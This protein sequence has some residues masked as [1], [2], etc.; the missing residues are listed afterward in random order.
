MVKTQL[1]FINT[2]Y[3]ESGSLSVLTL[4]HPVGFDTLVEA[5][6]NIGEGIKAGLECDMEHSASRKGN[7]PYCGQCLKESKREVT[8]EDIAEALEDLRKGDNDSGG[9]VL[10]ELFEGRDWNL[11][12]D[13]CY[14]D[15]IRDMVHVYEWGGEIIGTLVAPSPED[16]INKDDWRHH[17]EIPDSIKIG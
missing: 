8:S 6:T 1:L 7:C 3:A 14:S 4:F 15:H 11:W 2:G 16:T 12:F 5:L 17:M 10:E 13:T 9:A